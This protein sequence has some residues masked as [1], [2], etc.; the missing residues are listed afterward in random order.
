VPECESCQLRLE[1]AREIAA[2]GRGEHESFDYTDKH[3]VAP[4]S[5]CR[6]A[7]WNWYEGLSSPTEATSVDAREV[8][9]SRPADQ[10]QDG[11]GT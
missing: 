2:H 6:A 3:A 11:R 7:Q 4:C 1:R 8:P 10:P 9:K 5:E